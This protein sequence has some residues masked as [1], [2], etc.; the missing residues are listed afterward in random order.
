MP[1]KTALAES[2]VAEDQTETSLE[3]NLRMVMPEIIDVD[4]M[5]EKV[6]RECN[7][8]TG[9]EEEISDWIPRTAHIKCWVP[10]EV[11]HK[12]LA[13]R[14]KIVRLK[15]M[16]EG[17]EEDV[18]AAEQQELMNWVF[19]Q[20]FNVWQLTERQMTLPRL[21]KGIGFEVAL[22]LFN[23]FF[24]AFLKRMQSRAKLQRV[25]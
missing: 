24:D 12:M 10:M 6:R 21:R 16:V 22:E 4:F 18:N 17:D 19:E 14:N 8:A 7:E 11:F 15:K 5:E 9:E 1:K 13:G 23:R 20:V 25:G 2:T 3:V